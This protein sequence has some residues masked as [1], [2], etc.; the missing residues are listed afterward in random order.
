MFAKATRKFVDEI[1]PDGC[2]IPVSRRNESD[3][4]TVFSLV[5]KRNP[6]WFWQK[7]KYMPTD[8][9]LNDVLLGDNPINPVLIETDFLKYNGTMENN[10]T[11]GA[12]AGV[13]PG[14]LNFEGKGSSKLASSFGNLKK[15]ELDVQKL[16]HDSKNRCLDFQHSLLKQTLQRRSEVFALVKERIITTQTCTV[17]E[18]LQERGSCSAF[19]G[20]TV[21]KKIQV[22][23]KNGSLH[24][25]S[26][27]LV[28]IPAKTA[29]AYSLMELNVKKTGQFELC[30]MPD[31]YGSIEVDG[32][33]TTNTTLLCSAPSASP[34][35]KLQEELDKLQVQFKMLSGLPTSTRSCLFQ[36]ITLLL[37][38]KTAISTLD[39]ALEDLL[40]GKKSDLSTLDKEPSLKKAVQTTLELLKEK[41]DADHP[42][43]EG[44][45]PEQQ[46]EPSALTATN[47]ITS[48]LEGMT[49][50]ALSALESCCRC[51]NI[52]ALYLL[53]QNFMG[54]KEC[55]MKDSTL[56]P[57]A[58]KD[59]YS[60][61]QE[62]F[63]SSSVTLSKEEDLIQAQISS[64]EGHFPLILCIAIFGLA[65]LVPPTD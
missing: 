36:Q 24:S 26:N 31:T 35:Q 59:T 61:V 10:K 9:T 3:N 44:V 28:E 55:S 65:S 38:D 12:E 5:I 60:K 40:H 33:H 42:P 4:L 52:Q 57:L 49:E 51:P 21:P 56:A 27:V 54:N 23:V 62:L 63:G 1:D 39:L 6:F 25:D 20:F 7:P 15:E 43:L 22:S 19:L 45:T 2:L 29:L 13:G 37:K 18:E 47:V 50:S 41:E 48:A 32:V 46:S 58:E 30:L 64:Q 17:T 34:F 8:F 16:L 11:G 53:V 14:N